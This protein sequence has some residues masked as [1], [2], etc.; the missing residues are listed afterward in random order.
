MIRQLKKGMSVSLVVLLAFLGLL[1]VACGDDDDATDAGVT[2]G[3]DAVEDAVADATP[4]AAEDPVAEVTPD[5]APDLVPDLPPDLPPDGVSDATDAADATLTDATDATDAAEVVEPPAP[6]VLIIT[7]VVDGNLSGGLPKW[8]ELTNVGQEDIDLSDYSLGIY[9]NGATVLGGMAGTVR[10]LLLSGT[11]GSCE[12]YVV[13]WQPGPPVDTVGSSAFHTVYGLDPSNMDHT[14][15]GSNG[16]DVVAL[17][18]GTPG[19][20]DGGDAL[21]VDVLGVIG[22]DGIVGTEIAAWAFQDGFARRL[23]GVDAQFVTGDACTTTGTTGWAGCGW[24]GTGEWMI[25]YQAFST[26]G[27]E[28]TLLQNMTFPFAHTSNTFCGD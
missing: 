21:L 15:G 24:A 8:V 27:T 23:P 14:L 3:E 25:E 2:P 6:G 19:R 22:T 10:A 28:A 12:S 5:L 13:N 17:F 18:L 1:F 16:D 26:A 20:A 9:Y 11:L 7:E 4:D